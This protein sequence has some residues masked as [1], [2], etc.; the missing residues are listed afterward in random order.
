MFLNKVQI[1]ERLQ[2]G[3]YILETVRAYITNRL[4]RTASEESAKDFFFIKKN[5]CQKH[6]SEVFCKK[7]IL[8]NIAYFTGKHLCW[9]LFLIKLQAILQLY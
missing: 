6:P 3:G 4:V 2:T 5:V 7:E 8:K 9:S 1:C